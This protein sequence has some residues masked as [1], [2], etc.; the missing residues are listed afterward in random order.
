M[1]Q[2]PSLEANSLWVIK[3]FHA[4]WWTWMFITLFHK[5]DTPIPILSWMNSIQTFPYYF[6]NIN[7]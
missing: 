6:L 1:Q 7:F 3:K 2:S 4:F 5:L